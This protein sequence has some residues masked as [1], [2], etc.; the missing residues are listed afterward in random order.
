MSV[1]DSPGNNPAQPAWTLA[2]AFTVVLLAGAATVLRFL[3]LARKPFW[4]DEAFSVEIALL[5]WHDFAR[6]LWWREANMSL[7]YVLLRGWLHFGSSPFFIR[8][9]SVLASLATLPAIFWLSCKLFDRRVGLIAV[10][11]LSCNAYHIRYAQEAR[12]YSLFVLLATL[13]SGFFVAAL[14]EPTPS[15]RSLW[16]YVLTSVLAVYAHFYA[17]LLIA[18]QWLSAQGFKRAHG[19]ESLSALSSAMRRAW[20]WIGLAVLPLLAFVAKTGAGQIRWIQRPGVHDLL[21][22]WEHLAGNDGLPLALLGTAARLGA[23]LPLGGRL[24]RRAASR[25]VWRVQFL[26]IWMIFPVALA[27][28]LS[29][30]RPLFLARYFAFCLPALI[31]LA[32]AGLASLRKAWMTGV[33]LAV[34]L[35]LSL[36]GTLSYY[37]HDFDLERDGSEAAANYIYD[38]AQ[39]GDAI[40]FHIAEGRV[41]YEFVGSLRRTTDAHSSSALGPT[42]IFP[43]HG[44]H[45]DYRDVTGKPSSEFMHSVPETYARVWVVLMSNGA[46]DRPDATTLMLNQ[47]FGESFPQM[48]RLQFPQVE[49]RLYSKPS[50]VAPKS[51]EPPPRYG[52]EEALGW[53]RLRRI[54]WA[55]PG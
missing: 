21:D 36:Q 55:G 25:D 27:L 44:D 47:A 16:G 33:C 42:I 54:T 17:L 2:S 5:S 46:P 45:L 8:S 40:L 20:I 51:T 28:L 7:Y 49:V 10:A 6:L 9:L 34:M 3:F 53:E 41:P 26:L 13:S 15:R 52:A 35:L 12:S 30:A 37:D 18:S 32:A 38:H 43:R 4:F 48:Q 24:F 14:R 39:P 11:L 31:I 19:P 1:P 50:P 23:I 29:M 22:Y